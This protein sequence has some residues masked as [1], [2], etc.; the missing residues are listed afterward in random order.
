MKGKFPKS[1]TGVKSKM[2]EVT[3]ESNYLF[4]WPQVAEASRR[5]L[6][7]RYQL[8]PYLYTL[9]YF[10]STLGTPVFTPL[11]V[12]FWLDQ[13]TYDIDHQFMWGE[14]LLF[15]PVVYQDT[16]EVEAYF[17]SGLWYNLHDNSTIDAVSAGRYVTL[18]TSILDTNVHVRGGVVIPMQESAMTTTAVR[19]SPFTLLVPLSAAATAQ[20]NLII[21][22]GEQVISLSLCSLN[23]YILTAIR[24]DCV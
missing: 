10:A 11:W 2:F 19:A 22:D 13:T 5:A 24:A 3:I 7:T 15:S 20:G 17:P 12:N 4:R 21:D 6:S 9:H 8:L 16:Y 1:C 23:T 14:G 18:P